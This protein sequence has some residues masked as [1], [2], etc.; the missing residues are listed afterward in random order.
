V[1]AVQGAVQRLQL[2]LGEQRVGE[3]VGLKVP[4]LVGSGVQ[5]T[6]G[7][8]ASMP[9]VVARTDGAGW[10]V[11]GSWPDAA[12]ANRPA[13]GRPARVDA[14]VACHERVIQSLERQLHRVKKASGPAAPA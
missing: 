3:V 5:T 14:K 6:A 13:R 1:R 9:A 4:H 2:G 12:V 8:E 7:R 10:R 11:E